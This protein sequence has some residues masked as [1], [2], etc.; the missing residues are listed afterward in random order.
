MRAQNGSQQQIA[1]VATDPLIPDTLAE[2]LKM[3]I[4]E[5]PC[6]Y[7][8]RDASSYC[9]KDAMACV[10]WNGTTVAEPAT[11][12]TDYAVAFAYFVASCLLAVQ[13]RR[14][15]EK[16]EQQRCTIMWAAG[17]GLLAVSF[18]LAGTEH[19]FAVYTMCG[20]RRKSC[21]F[22]SP[23]WVVSMMTAV[24]AVGMLV[25]SYAARF[26][27]DCELFS[28]RI[29]SVPMVVVPAYW[30]TVG[31]GAALESNVLRSF[32]VMVAFLLPLVV[33][34]CVLCYW[35]L[36][37][38]RSPSNSVDAAAEA[39]PNNEN[40]GTPSCELKP[41]SSSS[42]AARTAGTRPNQ[43]EGSPLVH[44]LHVARGLALVVLAQLWNIPKVNPS[45]WFNA[46]DVSHT[47]V[48]FA[49]P[50]LYR[51]AAGSSDKN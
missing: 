29:A 7:C 40:T 37:R 28:W 6:E 16:G 50:F 4:A 2:A 3:S 33:Q 19:G 51:G 17:F 47:I 18:A 15:A 21:S 23:L 46:N 32:L 35:T 44:E 25:L 36:R 11:M 41:L 26:A 49:V 48:F 42:V 31:V 30:V 38:L 45:R 5:L 9:G 43:K 13:Y 20:E 14:E 24:A 1:A 34:L 12:L 39:Q 22:C 10:E 8:D 27:S